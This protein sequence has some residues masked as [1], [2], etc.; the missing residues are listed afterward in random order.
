M[1]QKV[2]KLDG[3]FKI[4]EYYTVVSCRSRQKKLRRLHGLASCRFCL[5]L[6][7][8]SEFVLLPFGRL[9]VD[10]GETDGTGILHVIS[11]KNPPYVTYCRSIFGVHRKKCL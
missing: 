11:T 8:L 5:M 9:V 1:K 7:W 2:K 6:G 3:Y 10:I 4:F